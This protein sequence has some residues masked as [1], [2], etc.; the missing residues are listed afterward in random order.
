L[1][2]EFFM[3]NKILVVMAVL[4]V[5]LVAGTIVEIMYPGAELKH[6]L[7]ALQQERAEDQTQ[8]AEYIMQNY[9]FAQ[10][11]EFVDKMNRELSAIQ[12]ELDLFSAR[13]EGA[14]A[15]LKMDRNSSIDATR[16]KLA[17]TKQQLD[18]TK[19]AGESDWYN[20]NKHFRTLYVELKASVN[21]TRQQM[22]D[23]YPS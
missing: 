15:P 3:R 12:K 7:T 4:F 18:R 17:G 19:N 21:K 2:E 6:S 14:G 23:K 11:N 22:N 5:G 8:V 10:K 16:V 1:K 13:V 20:A 9:T